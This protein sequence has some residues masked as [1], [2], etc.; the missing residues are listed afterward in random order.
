[1]AEKTNQ[2]DNLRIRP[3][4]QDKS[5]DWYRKQIKSLSSN[6]TPNKLMGERD[7][8]VRRI[9]PGNLYMFYYDPKFKEKLPFYDTFPLL[10]PYKKTPDGFIGYNMHYIPPVLRFKLMGLL[11]NVQQ[12]TNIELKKI[13]YS[14]GVLNASELNKYFAPCIKRYLTQHV[15]SNFLEI[16]QDSWLSASLLP[17]ERFIKANKNTVWKDTISKV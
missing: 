17:T 4:D 10:Y 9:M 14:Y 1:M 7:N 15:K 3:E 8:L 13:S 12:S 5:I 16:P 11:L 2:F 6:L